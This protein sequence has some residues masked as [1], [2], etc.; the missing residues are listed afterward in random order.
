MLRFIDFH[1]M[2]LIQTVLETLDGLLKHYPED[3]HQIYRITN[4]YIFIFF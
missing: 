4:I 1:E 2:K 3:R